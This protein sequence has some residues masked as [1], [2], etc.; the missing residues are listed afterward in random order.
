[1]PDN[2]ADLVNKFTEKFE[3]G[4]E[5]FSNLATYLAILERSTDLDLRAT[6]VDLTRSDLEDLRYTILE[7]LLVVSKMNDEDAEESNAVPCTISENGVGPFK[8]ERAARCAI[9]IYDGVSI[10]EASSRFGVDTETAEA[11]RDLFEQRL[12]YMGAIALKEN[13][14]WTYVD[15]LSKM[16]DIENFV[17]W[18]NKAIECL[19]QEDEE[20]N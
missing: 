6:S 14:E 4:E 17:D 5:Q 3:L 10:S 7:N 12:L 9:S 1:M 8:Y 18:T 13:P 20:N 19:I 16:T 2:E 11:I 15:V